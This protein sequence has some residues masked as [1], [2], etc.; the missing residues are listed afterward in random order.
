MAV[1]PE[2]EI[3]AALVA[4]GLG[5]AVD[6]FRRLMEQRRISVLCERGT[7]EDAG[8]YRATFYHGQRRLRMVVDASGTPVG[9]L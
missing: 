6:E 1:N 5:L 9:H 8:L 2:V 7:G 4:D 3:D